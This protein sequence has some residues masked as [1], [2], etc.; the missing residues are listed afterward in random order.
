MSAFLSGWLEMLNV[1]VAAYRT[2]T[3]VATERVIDRRV[4]KS[5]LR[6]FVSFYSPPFDARIIIVE[7]LEHRSS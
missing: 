7:R 2:N 5:S 4:T 6:T 3:V 1:R